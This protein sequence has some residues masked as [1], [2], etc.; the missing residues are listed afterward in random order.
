MTSTSTVA[1]HT[2][3]NVL[4]RNDLNNYNYLKVKIVGKGGANSGATV[5]AIG[6][7]VT[8]TDDISSATL[9]AQQIS[10]G[11]GAGAQ[12]CLML[13]FGVTPSR[14]YTI[15]V[16]FPGGATTS[17]AGVIPRLETNQTITITQP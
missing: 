15:S 5:D 6:A 7:L 8:V 14:P 2:T 3:A 13:H 11:R 1:N 9:Y 10:G 17:S 16:I 4:W 12:D